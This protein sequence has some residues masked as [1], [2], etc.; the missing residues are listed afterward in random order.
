MLSELKHQ[1]DI[2]DGEGDLSPYQVVILPD[3]VPVTVEIRRKLQKHLQRDGILIS[4]GWAGLNPE[5]TRFVLDE[6]K[7]SYEGPEPHDPSFFLAGKEIARGLPKMPITIYTSGVAIRSKH[8]ARVLAELWGSYFNKGSWDRYHENAYMPPNNDSGRPALVQCGRVFHFSFPIFAGYHEH[9]VVAYKQ[10]VGNCLERAFPEPL[11]KVREMPSFGQV[12]V[13]CRGARRMVH[14]LSYVPEMRG[15][16][17]QIIEEPIVV[18][19]VELALRADGQKPRR[20]YLAPTREPLEFRTDG[21]YL[22]VTVP[23]V[24]GY[25]LVV[26]EQ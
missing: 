8:G 14:L 21:N 7:I 11:V 1:F 26:F 6:Y 10:L 24:N 3:D 12:T 18:R 20:A 16:S 22:T 4:S 13:A 2:S 15:R 5:K 25:Q 17:T 19:S 23:E 9:A